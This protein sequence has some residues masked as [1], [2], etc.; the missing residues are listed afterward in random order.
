MNL[1]LC[2]FIFLSY[3][4]VFLPT[5]G[6]RRGLLLRLFTLNDTHMHSHSL[7]RA[8]LDEGSARRRELYLTTHNTHKSQISMLPTGFET[9]IPDSEGPQTRALNRAATGIGDLV[10]HE[11]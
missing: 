3:S 11:Y 5:Y 9:A 7:G 1:I 4:D 8:P 10:D 6:G 2:F